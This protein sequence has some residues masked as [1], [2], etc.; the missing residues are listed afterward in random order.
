MPNIDLPPFWKFAITTKGKIYYYHT[1]IRIPQWEPPI[2]LPSLALTDDK[3]NDHVEGSKKSRNG[4][5][6]ILCF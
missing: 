1:K 2:F 5:F 4:V 3:L 6:L